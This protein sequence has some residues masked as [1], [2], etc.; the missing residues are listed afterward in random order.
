MPG[1]G[2]LALLTSTGAGRARRFAARSALMVGDGCCMLLAALGVAAVLQG[3]PLL[4]KA[5]QYAGAGYLVSLGLR[6]MR[7]TRRRSRGRYVSTSGHD[8][9]QL[10]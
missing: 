3:H 9:R 6:L 8:F 10:S 1:P 7:A 2:T 4:F 5:L